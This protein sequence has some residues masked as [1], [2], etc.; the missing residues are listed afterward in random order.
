MKLPIDDC[1]QG[2]NYDQTPEELDPGAFSRVSNVRF[3]EGAAE[4]CGGIA[5]VFAAPSATPYA[6]HQHSTPAARFWVEMGLATAYADDGTTRINLTPGSPPTG[7]IDDRWSVGSFANFVAACNG[8][9][10][11]WTW[12]GNTANDFIPMASW[13]ATW[14]ADVVRPFRQFLVALGVSKSGTKQPHTIAWSN[15]AAPG[16]LPSTWTPAASNEAGEVD[17]VSP[18]VMVDFLPL[19]DIGIIYKDSS[20][21]AMTWVGGNEVFQFRQL[22]GNVGAMWRGCVVD[23]PVGHVVLTNGDV[24]VHQGQGTRSIL[25]GRMRKWLFR[26]I[27]PTYYKRSFLVVNAKFNEVWICFPSSGQQTCNRALLWNWADNTFGVRELSGVTCGAM[28]QIPSALVTVPTYLT[29]T[30][31]YATNASSYEGT[32]YLANDLR[33]MLGNASAFGL[34][35]TGSTDYGANF[36]AVLE[37]RGLHFGTRDRVKTASGLFPVFDGPT[38]TVVMV[39]IGGAMVPDRLPSYAA[40]VPF[41]FGTNQKIDAF[42]T[43]RYLAWRL[44]S[45]GPEAWRIRSAAFEARVGGRF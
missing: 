41:T 20:M 9:D 25:T 37:R 38:G 36:T 30:G 21:W 33:T 19:G 18:G 12:D 1:S 15:A 39:E 4:R 42:A 17:L 8:K 16:A 2:A 34:A 43:G 24:V 10:K 14:L 31:T 44:T 23:T 6:L 22:P 26:S 29:V 32:E 40:P 27:D 11:P 35:D 7:A 5:T 28:G 13:P 3:K 45:T